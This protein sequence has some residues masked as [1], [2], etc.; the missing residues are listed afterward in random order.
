MNICLCTTWVITILCI[1]SMTITNGQLIL[2]YLISLLMY[3][4]VLA[5]KTDSTNPTINT[6]TTKLI[7]ILTRQVWWNSLTQHTLHILV[8]PRNIFVKTIYSHFFI[9]AFGIHFALFFLIIGDR[10]LTLISLIL[11]LFFCAQTTLMQ[12]VWPPLT[13][14]T[15]L[16]VLILL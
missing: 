8:E 9:L 2:K 15:A 16:L 12:F 5:D 7:S 11:F 1:L 13:F 10:P 4:V 6:D 14:S 3:M